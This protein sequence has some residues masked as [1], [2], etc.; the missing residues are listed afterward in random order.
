M[1]KWVEYI[2]RKVGR[3]E[4]VRLEE[5]RVRTCQVFEWH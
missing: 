3:S 4:E 1:L 2:R 5:V